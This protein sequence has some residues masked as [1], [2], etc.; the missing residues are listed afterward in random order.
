LTCADDATRSNQAAEH[1]GYTIEGSLDGATF[2]T[3]ATGTMANVTNRFYTRS[4]TFANVQ[5]YTIY[6]VTFPTVA[7]MVGT[8]AKAANSMQIADVA[9][10]GAGFGGTLA[11]PAEQPKITGI[12]KNANGSITL[13]WTGGGTLQTATTVNGPYSSVTGATS[14][15]TVTPPSS[16]MFGRIMK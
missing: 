1:H 13:T 3:I 10:L 7:N 2:A 6:R 15:F 8:T 12:V 9:L 11:A 14:P 5:P 16:V 4:F